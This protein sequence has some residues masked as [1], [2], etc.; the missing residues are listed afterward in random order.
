MSIG[1]GTTVAPPTPFT[2][3]PDVVCNIPLNVDMPNL[4]PDYQLSASSSATS[5]TAAAAGRLNNQYSSWVPSSSN[6]DQWHQVDFLAP[7]EVAGVLTQGSPKSDR[8]VSTFTVSTSQDGYTFYPVRDD[9]GRILIYTGNSDRD[10]VIRNYFP[11]VITT[12]FVRLI[13]LTWGPEGFGLRLNYI[14]CFAA[15]NTPRPPVPFFQPTGIPT[16]APKPAD[17]GVPTVQPTLPDGGTPTPAPPVFPTLEPM[18]TREMGLQNQRIIEDKQ[19]TASSNVDGHGPEMGRLSDNGYQGSWIPAPTDTDPYIQVDFKEP[20]LLAA[21][22]TQGDGDQDIW[23]QGYQVLY[24]LDGVDFVPYAEKQDGVTKTFNGN[25]DMVTPVTN[26][27]VKNIIARYIR[28]LPTSNYGGVALRFDVLGCN[29][30]GENPAIPT[31]PPLHTPTPAPPS[32]DGGTPTPKPGVPVGGTPTPAPPTGVIQIPPPQVCLLPMG[33]VDRHLVRDSQISASSELDENHSAPEGRLHSTGSWIPSIKE[34]ESWIMLDLGRPTL[35]SGV[36]TQGSPDSGRHV[37]DYHIYVSL[38]GQ[39]FM[40]YSDIPGGNS[41][42][43]FTG[44]SDQTTPLRNLFN[45]DLLARYVRIVPVTA[46]P[47]GIGMRFNV[48][49]CEPS[50]PSQ[51]VPTLKPP[52]IN[53]ATPTPAPGVGSTG[54]PSLPPTTDT[55]CDVPMGVGNPRI[56]SDQQLSASSFAD[57]NQTPSRGR[58]YMQ[59]DGSLAG[60]WSP[61]VSNNDQFLQIDFLDPY[62]ISGVVTQ[63]RSDI[64]AWV[65]QYAVYYSSDGVDF[66]PV[67]GADT[68]PIVFSGNSDQYTPVK[69]FF[70]ALV[71]ARFVQIR[72]LG[73]HNSVGLR[74]DLYGCSSPFPLPPSVAQ[75]TPTPAPPIPSDA[76]PTRE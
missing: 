55:P 5:Q 65:T 19:M 69:N 15:S 34:P 38:N 73:F 39:D 59:K 66:H 31:R 11:Q 72:P 7:V 44:N 24:S 36:I 41:P 54:T 57:I 28:L 26:F 49:G 67:L 22:V 6:V 1:E 71:F 40:A 63:G 29:P 74:F 52:S 58:I 48:I 50:I 76:T 30:S 21:I 25:T 53:G 60:G 70:P 16:P 2:H 64:E 4:I 51:G 35:V 42:Y 68:K 56:V 23:V 33:T 10:S 43:L 9:Q 27:F 62:E 47:E 17:S 37:Q 20:K 8:W 46:S 12:R 61:S 75:G 45:R 3:E 18:C 13:P 32:Q 14:G